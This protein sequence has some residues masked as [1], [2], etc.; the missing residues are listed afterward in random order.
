MADIGF[1]ICTWGSEDD[2]P[3][4]LTDAERLQIINGPWEALV[5]GLFI[6]ARAKGTGYTYVFFV[7]CCILRHPACTEWVNIYMSKKTY[8]LLFAYC[9]K[10]FQPL[11]DSESKV[12]T[13]TMSWEP[14]MRQS[15]PSLNLFRAMWC[16]MNWLVVTLSFPSLPPSIHF[17]VKSPTGGAR[18]TSSATARSALHWACWILI[19]NYNSWRWLRVW[20][21]YSNIFAYQFLIHEGYNQKPHMWSI[22]IIVV[23]I[24][25]SFLDAIIK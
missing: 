21:V 12:P 5:Y 4:P 8:F 9:M 6:Y 25:K 19:F 7:L 3:D 24:V 15:V 18:S 11:R 16:N 23:R 22:P 14:P 13:Q 1:S 2:M 10:R 20:C 17:E